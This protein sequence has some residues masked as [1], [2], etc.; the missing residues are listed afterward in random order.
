MLASVSHGL[1]PKL[2]WV[3]RTLEPEFP[4]EGVRG[5]AESPGGTLWFSSWGNGLVSYDGINFRKYGIEEGL[6]SVYLR[7]CSFDGSGSLWITSGDGLIQ[8]K[9]GSFATFDEE[10]GFPIGNTYAIAQDESGRILVGGAGGVV[11]A[12]KDG[13]FH[14]LENSEVVSET[15]KVKHLFVD[16]TLN[17]LWES[18][19]NGYIVP[20]D[21]STLKPHSTIEPKSFS[22][23]RGV[24]AVLRDD[25]D[26]LWVACDYDLFREEGSNWISM[27]PDF[28][29]ERW[30]VYDLTLGPEGE[31]II[32]SVQGVLIYD[33]GS[34]SF[35]DHMYIPE[36]NQINTVYSSR[37]GDIW[38]GT[39]GKVSVLLNSP[40]KTLLSRSPFEHRFTSLAIDRE[41]RIWVGGQTLTYREEGVWREV[42]RREDGVR[43]HV[44]DLRIG[45]DGTVYSLWTNLG[46]LTWKDGDEHWLPPPPTE[47]QDFDS[48]LLDTEERLWVG[49]QRDGIV[50]WNGS[51]WD[52]LSEICPGIE[53][54]I[55]QGK[56]I[57]TLFQGSDGT[58]LIGVEGALY[59]LEDCHLQRLSGPMDDSEYE[60]ADIIET[61]TGVYLVGVSGMGLYEFD[62]ENWKPSEGWEKGFDT[63]LVTTLSHGPRDEI[64]V[65]TKANGLYCL[66]EGGWFHLGISEGLAP[67]QV[68]SLAS[69]PDSEIYFV[70]D[71][72]GLMKYTRDRNPPQ[73]RITALTQNV[74]Y[75]E[76]VVLA[77]DGHDRFE[78]TK[79]EDLRY[80][81][82]IDHGEWSSPSAQQPIS[83]PSAP[84]GR[85]TIAVAAIDLAGNRDLT[86]AIDRFLVAYPWWR[87][88]LTLLLGFVL[89]LNLIL[90]AGFLIQRFRNLSRTLEER[91]EYQ[92]K[93][94]DEVA[95]RTQKLKETVEFR[96]KL[97]TNVSHDFRTPLTNLIGYAQMLGSDPRGNLDEN[98][99]EFVD[100]IQNNARRMKRLIENVAQSLQGEDPLE[101]Y[102]KVPVDLREI[103]FDTLKSHALSAQDQ[104]IELELVCSEE[105]VEVI[106]SDVLIG[107]LLDN[108]LS[109]AIKFSNPDS[110]V[111]I[112]ITQEKERTEL[113]VIDEGIGIH[114]QDLPRIFDR[115]SQLHHGLKDHVGGLG[116]G[117][118]ICKEIADYHNAEILVDSTIDSG[119][120]FTVVWNEEK[121]EEEE[122][123]D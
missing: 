117:L 96:E 56:N 73:T 84:M 27:K 97:I 90:L 12:S 18:W 91:E 30:G 116:I 41:N 86:P 2:E 49:T 112:R 66:R 59:R 24:R 122:G 54:E 118:S 83:I 9:G 111:Q 14:L 39:K 3:S 4:L 115:F 92:R 35:F 57:Y 28:I 42:E 22:Q 47:P 62:G 43:E 102:P 120:T 29:D 31:V 7:H 119:S 85:H 88:P 79:R 11:A 33:H 10:N 93:L 55:L 70:S 114:S 1:D 103:A 26:R 104:R 65:G 20:I 72:L 87:N 61:E 21:L 16:S 25:E 5:I 17:V 36:A 80:S 78:D 81:Y 113:A 46:V 53:D 109:N 58:V 44:S 99:R 64:W 63:N 75:G 51:A 37:E 6:P 19:D 45:K 94:E 123:I 100:I 101:K 67:C 32:A 105:R 82:R 13:A 69:G 98:Q 40:V 76:K 50:V 110:E 34:W 38:V 89:A 106:G 121:P 107:R 60:V 71:L 74:V 68:D 23:A 8:M 48:L 77:A 108:L 52:R 15:D 95:S